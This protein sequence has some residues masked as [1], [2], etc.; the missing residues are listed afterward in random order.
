MAAAKRRTR[1]RKR[2][3][4]ESWR[5]H[6]VLYICL[7][8]SVLVHLAAIVSFSPWWLGR[9]TRVKPRKVKV[10][11][12]KIK[13]RPARPRPPVKAPPRPEVVRPV[14]KP[15]PPKPVYTKKELARKLEKVRSEEV[16]DKFAR[17][18]TVR[19][20]D[21]IQRKQKEAH[22]WVDRELDSLEKSIAREEAGE[23]GY[24]RVIDMKKSSDYQV[25]RLMDH[26]NIS[27]EH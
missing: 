16:L 15:P 10:V 21:V 13:P 3:R 18:K 25:G 24:S 9:A 2:R 11:S 17:P 4:W 7:I 27:V 12:L 19:A 23:V 5:R 14:E 1:I 8:V 26:F 22:L 6:K 20:Q